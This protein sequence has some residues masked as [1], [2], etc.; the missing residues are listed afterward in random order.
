MRPKITA[1]RLAALFAMITLTTLTPHSS[2]VAKATSTTLPTVADMVEE[3]WELV[4]GDPDPIAVGPQIT[5]VMS[6]S[7]AMQPFRSRRST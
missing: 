1:L 5:T 3:D 2:R 4:I 6:L 7:Q